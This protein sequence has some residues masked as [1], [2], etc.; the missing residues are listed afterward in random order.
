VFPIV[1]I[2][3]PEPRDFIPFWFWVLSFTA[4]LLPFAVSAFGGWLS[5]LF[6]KNVV[7]VCANVILIASAVIASLT[8]MMVRWGSSASTTV[9]IAVVAVAWVLI[10]PIIWGEMH[11]QA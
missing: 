10:S 1:E 2:T 4:V 3:L 7:T 11:D 5:G 9:L 6:G 8:F